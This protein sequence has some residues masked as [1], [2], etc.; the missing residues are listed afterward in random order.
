MLSVI[1][2]RLAAQLLPFVKDGSITKRLFRITRQGIGFQ[3]G[4]Y[5]VVV[6]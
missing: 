6:E 2:K 5:T 3:A 1:Q 4:N